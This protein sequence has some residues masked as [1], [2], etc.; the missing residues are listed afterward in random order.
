MDP[1]RLRERT[2]SAP[3]T[4]PP[5]GRCCGDDCSALQVLRRG[6]ASARDFRAQA[7]RVSPGRI[8]AS[9][10]RSSITAPDS[11]AAARSSSRRKRS[12][13]ADRARACASS[14]GSTEIGQGTRTMHA[15][16]V[17]DALGI[18]Y[19]D[20]EVGAAGHGAGRP[21][22]DRR[23]RRAPAWSS[24]RSS[25]RVRAGDEG[26]AR[27]HARRRSTTRSTAPS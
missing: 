24:A 10:S 8:A 2:R 13:G 11:P 22:A 23:S 14:S 27:R 16:I 25:Q 4:P 12:A 18:P 7:R 15:Q 19:E 21:T 20:V 1:V 9:G 17:A 3:A 26:E 6:R 5:P